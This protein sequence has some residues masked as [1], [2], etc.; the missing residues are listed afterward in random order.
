MTYYSYKKHFSDP[1]NLM[2]CNSE[3][4]NVTRMEGVAENLPLGVGG[5]MSTASKSISMLAIISSVVSVPH[6]AT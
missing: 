5:T 6:F 2:D 1:R 3:K 4:L